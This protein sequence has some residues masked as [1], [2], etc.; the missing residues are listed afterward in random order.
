[1]RFL[2]WIDKKD[3]IKT[4]SGIANPEPWLVDLF[5]ATPV[6]SG[7]S[8]TPHNA[9]QCAPVACAVKAIAET[10]GQLPVHVYER[11]ADAAKARAPD[12]PVHALLHDQVNDWTSASELRET[13]TADALLHEHGAFAVIVR[14]E[15]RPVEL[16]RLAP[17]SVQV[18]HDRAT[19]EPVSR[20][21]ATVQTA[22]NDN[23]GLERKAF[24]SFARLGEARMPADEVKALVVANDAAGGYLAP[25]EI[26]REILK[27]LVEFSPIRQFARV[28]TI[29]G[30]E[31]KYPRRVSGTAATWVS[32]I[33]DRTGSEPVFDQMT[34]TPHE[35]ATFTDVSTQLLEDNAYNLE[36]ELAADFGES[37]GKTEG[38]AFVKGDGTGKP[39]GLMATGTGIAE[40]KTGAAA[41]FPSSNPADVIIGMYHSLPTAHAQNGVWM[42]NRKTLGVIRTWK[43]STG[44]YLVTDPISEGGATTLL[45]RPIV[46]AIDMDDI[47]ANA[48][49]ILF[50]DMQGYRIV[51]R[52]GLSFLRD[53]YTL[54]GKGQ[55]RFHA[56]KR[57]G[58]DVTHPD[59]FVKLKVAA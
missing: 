25:E 12:H 20:P 47:A 56:R 14:V 11:G 41:N 31:I 4:K 17:E 7:I 19:G 29:G 48:F 42:L 22:S 39:K 54:A 40:I 1:M 21:G 58:A 46:E 27:T 6:S 16:H 38:L 34:M 3:A 57:V 32:E 33:A 49:P 10:I 8:V 9:M 15:G 43:D 44:R 26:G 52:V 18:D 2:K 24:I 45:G 50:G 37:F 28:I 30:S 13:L 53:P 23:E 36:G 55:V 51:D 5:G 35:L 59:R